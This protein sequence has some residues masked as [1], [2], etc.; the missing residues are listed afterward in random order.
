MNKNEK[1]VC[2]F[3]NFSTINVHLLTHFSL[4]KKLNKYYKN[5]Y[6]I[7][8]ENFL[9]KKK[10]FF[11]IQKQFLK[12]KF[13]NFS[14]ETSLLKFINNRK[15]IVIKSFPNR[16]EYFNVFKFL[17]KINCKQVMISNVG[18]L[19]G[20]F[21]KN[22]NNFSERLNIIYKNIIVPKLIKFLMIL[23]VF[24]KIDIR[25]ISNKKIYNS[26]KKKINKS[27]FYKKYLLPT[28]KIIL[29][30]SSVYDNYQQ[31]RIKNT[32]KYIVHVDLDLTYKH[33]IDNRKILNKNKLK[34]HYQNLEKFLL[35]ISNM[36][37]KKVIVVIHPLYNLKL[38]KNYL[39]KFDVY[40]YRSKEFLRQGFIISDFGS[41]VI[42]ESI[43]GKKKIISLRS[44][45]LHFDNTIYAKRLKLLNHSIDD[46]FE[47]S[48]S[49]LLKKL[50]YSTRNYG[51]YINNH[52]KNTKQISSDIIIKNINNL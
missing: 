38:I 39:K 5:F 18:N 46:K 3:V 31:S 35:N 23:R 24:K 40:K 47:Y 44:K 50:K 14:T 49:S 30:N 1:L 8:T 36:F 4:Y 28:K 2:V 25:F 15:V 27:F 16:F 32:N 34:K 26:T 6:F 29:V 43:I 13:K 21:M 42:T 37:N 22:T 33:D 9:K 52:H 7:N 19:Q 41:S 45:Y 17:N 12:F 48:K 10:I 11:N 20:N 51:K